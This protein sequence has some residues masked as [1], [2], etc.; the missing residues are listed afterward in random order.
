MPLLLEQQPEVERPVGVPAPVRARVCRLR[1][2]ALALPLEQHAE[3]P[4]RGR[5][6]ISIR[7][8]VRVRGF[9]QIAL[10]LEALT[11]LEHVRG[12]WMV[13]GGDGCG[14]A[15]DPCAEEQRNTSHQVATSVTR[16]ATASRA[17]GDQWRRIPAQAHDRMRVRCWIV[18]RNNSGGLHRNRLISRSG[19]ETLPGDHQPQGRELHSRQAELGR[20]VGEPLPRR[21]GAFAELAVRCAG[22][23]RSPA[24]VASSRSR[25]RG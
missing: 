18:T 2:G 10:L 21:V 25:S 17:D 5:V 14:R 23:D 12:R 22:S 19:Y 15:T 20:G 11:T 3:V 16:H 6:P 13:L 4:R 8:A 7:L 1:G 9:R 24:G